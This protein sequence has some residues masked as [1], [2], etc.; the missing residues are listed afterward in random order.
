MPRLETAAQWPLWKARAR[1]VLSEV[2]DVIDVKKDAAAAAAAAAD[3]SSSS[4]SSKAPVEPTVKTESEA[5]KLKS[6]RAYSFFMQV[7][8]DEP[9]AL[10]IP[11]LVPEDDAAGVWSALVAHYERKTTA[12][13]AHT[14]GMLHKIHMSEG[15]D[16]DT[17]KARAMQLSARLKSMGETVSE[18]ELIHVILQGL[19][20][21]FNGVRAALD[22]MDEL[23]LEG[24][25]NHLR[26]YQEKKKYMGRT[27]EE[28]EVACYGA[29]G[30]ARRSA[31]GGGGARGRFGGG[32][33]G[34][35]GARRGAADEE[36]EEDEDDGN[37]E[38]TYRC[39]LCRKVGH[40]E[41][42]CERRRGDGD[43]CYRCGKS[44]HQMRRCRE[45]KLESSAFAADELDDD[46]GYG[47]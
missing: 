9:L 16:Y 17:F 43:A 8:G 29:A 31:R 47:F 18:G 4:S 1:G 14:R 22:V 23:T 24:I 37:D 38:S 35:R 19:P 44:G 45:Q 32:R 12:S 15:E 30:A 40:W 10:V 11:P 41:Q 42:Y 33:G 3:G 20:S 2:W 6:M 21:S 27:R 13:K 7:L 26:D 34:G 25:S 46:V 28:D 5:S 39:R 36:D